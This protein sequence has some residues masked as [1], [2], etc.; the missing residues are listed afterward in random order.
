GAARG[1]TFEDATDLADL[2]DV[3]GADAPDDGTAVG[4]QVDDADAG[5]GDEGLADGRVADAE[6]SGKL[7]GAQVLSGPVQAPERSSQQ[8]L[9]DGLPAQ[10][11]ITSQSFGSSRGRHGKPLRGGF[12]WGVHSGRQNVL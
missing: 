6:A 8:L 5:Q 4:Q 9:D 1:G 11:V 3:S 10:A 7:L 12:G 2:V